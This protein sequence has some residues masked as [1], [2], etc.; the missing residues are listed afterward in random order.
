MRNRIAYPLLFIMPL[1]VLAG[2]RSNSY[3]ADVSDV[4]LEIKIGR[5]EQDLFTINPNNLAD[6][7]YYLNEK[8]G[9]FLRYFG[10]VINIGEPSDSTFEKGLVDFCT[11]KLN[12]EVYGSVISVFPDVVDIEKSLTMAF[13]HYKHYFPEKPVPAVSTCI[14]GFNNSIITGDS[15]LGIGLDRYLGPESRYYKQ[16]ML[17][18]YQTV[19]MNPE[20]I[21]PDCMYGW[22]ASEWDSGTLDYE[23]ENV[24]TE[25]V[26]EGK[27]WYFT[28]C[29]IPD[30]KEELVYGFTPVQLKFCR[31]NEGRMWQYL[32]EN[33]MLFKSDQLTIKKLTG[34]AAF[35][36]Y[37]STESPGRAAVWIGFRI[38]ESYMEKNREVTL[39][40]LMNETDLQKIL[41]K[42]RYRPAAK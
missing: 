6:S 36:T 42:A 14:T 4:K 38:V 28:R 16:L 30:V 1:L 29:M 32:I 24:L 26:H 40:D 33:N 39:S 23:Q 37:F 35:T 7:I 27:L 5:L 10:Y 34:E 8:Y 12:N 31:N 18:K 19:R 11:D 3:K 2:C 21:V 25:M 20:S 13:R 15:V 41:E 22:G 9:D 17:Y